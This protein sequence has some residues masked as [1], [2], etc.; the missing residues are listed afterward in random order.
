MRD[1]A[2]RK[3][4][5]LGV[6]QQKGVLAKCEGCAVE[7][8]K[9]N[10]QHRFCP[11]CAEQVMLERARATSLAKSGV[12]GSRVAHAAWY[13]AKRQSDPAYAIN[14]RFRAAVRRVLNGGKRGRKWESLVGYTLADL[15]HH[16]ERQFLKGMTWDNRGD[17]HI[18]HIVPLASF[19]FSSAEDPEFRA[20]WA[21][22][23]LRPLW[24][25]DNL[26]KNAT[27]THL[28]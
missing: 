27:R 24:A 15:M 25:V 18:D 26:R 10:K 9:S 21:L 17:W 11:K 7:I 28:I 4:R 2:T 16:L 12:A 6:V 20:A 22:T 23:N 3:R 14:F 8:V 5:R 13:K 19:S 1:V